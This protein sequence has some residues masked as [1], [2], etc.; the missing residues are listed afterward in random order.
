MLGTMMMDG[1]RFSRKVAGEKEY[2]DYYHGTVVYEPNI[3]YMSRSNS[4]VVPY[5]LHNAGRYFS[6]TITCE[7]Y[8]QSYQAL[9]LNQFIAAA[10]DLSIEFET[11][12]GKLSLQI[13]ADELPEVSDTG[14]LYP[15]SFTYKFKRLSS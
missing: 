4:A 14:R 8:M 5:L 12:N 10:D 11:K 2:T 1:V 7:L 15:D 9:F 3:E 6:A 13:F